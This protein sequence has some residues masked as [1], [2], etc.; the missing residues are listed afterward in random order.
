VDS[1]VVEYL[2]SLALTLEL[3][4]NLGPEDGIN[5]ARMLMSSGCVWFNSA[6]TAQG[7]EA[8]RQYRAAYDE[9]LKV[10]SDKPRHDWTSHYADAFRYLC[11]A[12]RALMKPERLATDR[13]AG[14]SM[15]DLTMDQFM[16][17]EDPP[18]RTERL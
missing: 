18:A 8:L 5:A 6:T 15:S 16:D 1:D 7:I 11:V 3:V 2:E 4:P 17:L 12:A 9:R 14:V 13:P 10:F